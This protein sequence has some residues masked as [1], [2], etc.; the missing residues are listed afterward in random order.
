MRRGKGG[1][2]SYIRSFRPAVPKK[3]SG[4]KTVHHGRVT[5]R[6]S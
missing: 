5:G 1:G 4:P 6:R 3:G 2:G